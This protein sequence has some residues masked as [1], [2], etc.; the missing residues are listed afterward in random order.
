MFQNGGIVV[1]MKFE[2]EPA[3]L[4]YKQSVEMKMFML[5]LFDKT[6]IVFLPTRIPH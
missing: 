1:L 2:K 4:K 6:P 3:S 5:F